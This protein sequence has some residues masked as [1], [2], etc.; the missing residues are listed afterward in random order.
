MSHTELLKLFATLEKI[1]TTLPRTTER[2]AK[3]SLAKIWNINHNSV[4]PFS[5]YFILEVTQ[6]VS[7]DT[8]Y[9]TQKT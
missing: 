6:P 4:T 2:M 1:T 5:A 9:E 3:I 8:Y 7:N